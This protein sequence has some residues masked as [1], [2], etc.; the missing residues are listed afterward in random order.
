[1]LRPCNIDEAD[2]L[3]PCFL[4]E[5]FATKSLNCRTLLTVRRA[6]V[7]G[8]CYFEGL[9]LLCRNFLRSKQ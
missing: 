1:M 5:T 7:S 3:A 8:V 4:L 2:P 6:P 9:V